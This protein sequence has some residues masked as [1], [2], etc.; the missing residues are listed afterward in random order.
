MLEVT[1]CK[2]QNWKER[3]LRT[4]NLVLLPTI[5]NYH[6]VVVFKDQ[7]LRTIVLEIIYVATLL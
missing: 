7:A 4:A 1:T 5:L 6:L 2:R 3:E